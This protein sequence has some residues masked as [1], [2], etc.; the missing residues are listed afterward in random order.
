MEV[1]GLMGLKAT[2]RMLLR[3]L[4]GIFSWALI[5]LRLT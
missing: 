4:S 1:M 5:L 3:V 2:A